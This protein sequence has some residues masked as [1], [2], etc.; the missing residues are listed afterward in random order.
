[1]ANELQFAG[2]T[3]SETA[4]Q[5]GSPPAGLD[6]LR[7][8]SG[9]LAFGAALA[10][11]SLLWLP[12][13]SQRWRW[14]LLGLGLLLGIGAL[15]SGA[16]QALLLL[17]IGIVFPLL[18]FWAMLWVYQRRVQHEAAYCPRRTLLAIS[19]LLLASLSS[20]AGGLLIHATLWDSRT[21]LHIGQFR[22]VTVALAL[23]ILLLAAYAWQ[24]E[25]LQ[26]AFDR[27]SLRLTDYWLRF[28]TLWQSPIRYG[29][30]AFIL[31]AVGALGVVLLRSGNDSAL[32]ASQLE[33]AMRG[34]LEQFFAVRPRS[35]EL[36]G[37]PLLV[38]FLLSLPWKSRLSLLI[39]LGAMLGQVSILNTFCHIHTPLEITLQR[40]GIGVLLGIGSGLLLALVLQ[41]GA[42]AW[43]RGRQRPRLD[44]K[45]SEG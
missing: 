27:A 40:V 23:P 33:T 9:G 1:V 30:V 5:P 31:L 10:L 43:E 34:S 24:A 21:M 11:L 41:G 42:W 25:T 28:T 15:A 17:G 39:G 45:G 4:A 29:D 44:S 2:Y 7:N 35:K 26:D 36:L 18:G 20:A 19:G 12:S 14:A 16:A 38:M 32:G 37:H 13:L 3:I 22:G 8:L 6:K